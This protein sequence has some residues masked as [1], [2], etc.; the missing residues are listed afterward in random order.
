MKHWSSVLL[1]A[2]ILM[3]TQ[4]A[5]AEP[6][7]GI[8]GE[9]TNYNMFDG[10]TNPNFPSHLMFVDREEAS[11]INTFLFEG[12]DLLYLNYT[13]PIRMFGTA[14]VSGMMLYSG[15]LEGR[16]NFNNAIGN[17]SD[18]RMVFFLSYAHK[19]R[20][21][22]IMGANLKTVTSRFS[23]MLTPDPNN[24]GVLSGTNAVSEGFDLGMTY[25]PLK[26]MYVSLSIINFVFLPFSSMSAA[27]K[28]PTNLKLGVNYLALDD[29]LS[30][31]LNT[32]FLDL[33]T[34]KSNFQNGQQMSFKLHYEMQ[35]FVRKWFSVRGAF[36]D[37]EMNFGV[38]YIGKDLLSLG[39]EMEFNYIAGYNYN[40]GMVTNRLGITARWGLTREEQESK[41]LA[42]IREM[43]PIN[44]FDEAMRLY[45]KKLYWEASYAFGKVVS[46]YPEFKRVDEA[47][48]YIAE[49]FFNL[50]YE[51]AAEYS[52]RRL[53]NEYPE[54][55]RKDE[56]T[57]RLQDIYYK[58]GEYD[59][60][61]EY[62]KKIATDFPGSKV[63]DDA[64]YLA[65]QVLSRRGD[66]VEAV[67]YY[68]SIKPGSDSYKYAQYALSL[69]FLHIG[70]SE[71]AIKNLQNVVATPPKDKL[72]EMIVDRA[73]VTL[74]H[75]YFELYDYDNATAN[76]QK[77]SSA[78]KF[79]DEALI[80]NGWSLV[81]KQKYADAIPVLDKLISDRPNSIYFNEAT[82]VKGYCYT[83]TRE[84]DKAVAEF[85]KVAANCKAEIQK[86]N[87]QK[88]EVPR[89][90]SDK[91]LEINSMK[92]KLLDVELSILESVLKKPS[93]QRDE[94]AQKF[95][96]EIGDKLTVMQNTVGSYKK[97][98]QDVKAVES[99]EKLVQDAEY[100]A[101]TA[102][103][104]QKEQG[105][106]EL[107][108]KYE[109]EIKSKEQKLLEELRKL[110]EGK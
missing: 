54:F 9:I 107:D 59:K 6:G 78:S 95:N 80:G 20:D 11:F 7:G 44:A 57:Y 4:F 98:Q 90:V 12:T 52:Y 51:D 13:R 43:A 87:I 74:G 34:D 69:C 73:Y 68:K 48:F 14:S 28:W 67:D 45:Q 61:M 46:L 38:S 10:V 3:G 85:N 84:Y 99:Y 23:E 101:A 70:D 103:H 47:N 1:L 31:G 2:S 36:D 39:E 81:N 94:D 66:K 30:L 65:G 89:L 63:M 29:Q 83:L 109:D 26:N 22:F 64:S 76:Y 93:K 110:E 21:D 88:T 55:K 18:L 40:I 105:R 42:Q 96:T 15:G 8:P 56:C 92:E 5:M 49:S 91:E 16:D 77:V 75:I 104:L 24:I 71:S 100:A 17:F 33:I 106:R 82:L 35:Y 58:R 32:D 86:K 37:K 19:L 27:D 50:G 72:E 102:A 60:V 53:I 79:F 108:K 25:I 41:R 97:F 62:Y